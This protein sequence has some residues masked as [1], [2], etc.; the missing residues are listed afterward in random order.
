[1]SIRVFLHTSSKRAEASALLDSGATENFINEGYA[2]WL[3]IPFKRLRNPREVY[4]VDGTPNKN[5]RIEFFTDLEVRTGEQRTK[6]RFF[7]TELG[8][9]KMILGYPWFA[10]AQPRIDWAKGWIDYDQLPV[11]LKTANAG[12]F[13][14]KTV[15]K[16]RR[17][18]KE[19]LHIAYVAFPDKKQTTASKLAEQHG[20]ANHEPLPEEYRRHAKVFGEKEAQRFPGPRLWDHAIELKPNAPATIPGKI[21]ALT[22]KE[23]VALTEFIQEHLKKGYIKPSKSP[24]ASP[25]FFIKK[26]DG[27]LRPVQDYR[28]VNEWT[29]KNR[30][31]LPLIPELIAR[32]KGAKLF[33]KFDV[34][35][36]Y[37]NVRIKEGDQWKAAFITN[38]G[39]FEP[40]VM[41][42]GLT[43]SPATF[44]T[45]M[46]TIFTEEVRE[47]WLTIYMDDMLIHTPEDIKLHRRCVHRVLD[48]L[49]RHD[50]FLKPEKCHFEQ[51]TME[52]LGVVLVDG[53]IKMDPAKIKG[54]ADW[55]TPQTVR[56][57]RAFL[58]FTG[59][60]RY[61]I[62]NY[63]AIARP[64]IHLTKKATPFHWEEPQVKA[65][66]TLKTLMCRKPILR[67]PDYTQPFFVSTDASA[68][69]VGAVL[70]QEGE[71]NPRT[72][73]PSQH[74]IAYYSATFT[75][76]ERNYDIYER[77]LLAVLKALEHWRPH[78]AATDIPVTIL[79]DH[80][81][82]TFWK[83]PRKVNRRVARW[84]ATLQDYNL[85]FKHVPGKLHAAPDMLSRPPGAS[86]GEEDNQNVTLIP[87]ES[88]IRIARDDSAA[89]TQLERDITQAQEE[90]LTLMQA[91]QKTG[92]VHRV[93]S[94]L[95]HQ[96]LFTTDGAAI[97]I[98]PVDSLK[99]E[100][101]R[102]N[103]DA[104]T[105]GHP[106][107]DQTFWNLQDQ[108]WWP[109][110]R[111]WTAQYVK[112]CATCQQSKP[113]NHP[114][115]TPLYRIPVPPD[116]LPFQIVAMDLITQLPNSA[117][118][119]AILTIVDHGCSRAAIF[120]PCKTRISGE[121]IAALYLKN[122]YPWFG[123]PTKTITDR[124]PRFTS[125]FA[126]ALCAQ[127]GVRQNISTAYHPQ[128]DGLS[129][130]KNQWV[131][132]YL[133]LLTM[134]D[135]EQWAQWLPVATA[136]H[137]QVVN[138]STGA[139]PIETILGYKPPLDYRS[140]PATLNPTADLRKETAFRK[141]EQAKA[142]L[143][144]LA[145]EIPINQYGVGDQVWLEAKNL[146]LP[147][148]THKL[149]PRRHGPF[150]ITERISPVA[151]RLQLP[152]AWTIHDVFHASLLT[153][154]Q[155]TD[156][157][158]VN[159][160]KPPPDLVQ[161]EEEFEVE[162]IR[163]HRQFGRARKLQYL[164]KW[165][166]YPE[167]DNSW[168]P[169][170]QVFAPELIRRYHL[171]HPLEDK[172]ARSSRR[173]AIRL[174]SQWPPSLPN[175]SSLSPLR[176]STPPRSPSQPPQPTTSSAPSSDTDPPP[177]VQPTTSSRPMGRA[178]PPKLHS[179][180]RRNLH[181]SLSTGRTGSML[182]LTPWDDSLSRPWP[183]SA[184]P[185]PARTKS[186][187][188]SPNA[189]RSW[190]GA[191][192]RLLSPSAPR[193]SKRTRAASPTSMSK[194]TGSASKHVTFAESPALASSR[195]PSAVHKTASIC[196]SYTLNRPSS[197]TPSPIPS[198]PGLSIV[199]RP[200]PPSSPTSCKRPAPPETG[201]SKLRSSGTTS[202]TPSSITFRGSS[203]S[204]KKRR[205]TSPSAAAPAYSA[206][207][208][209]TSGTV[210][211]PSK[212]SPLCTRSASLALAAAVGGLSSSRRV[213]TPSSRPHRGIKGPR[214][215]RLLN[216]TYEASR[217]FGMTRYRDHDVG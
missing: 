152:A 179:Y 49:Q 83:I 57:V 122:V 102:Q 35:W 212:P 201:A 44:Q 164:V 12:L 33:T 160:T 172:R 202:L 24:Y 205:T 117:G 130:R 116:A 56:D 22:Q 76:T 140:S 194:K 175:P 26:K 190:R 4:N 203:V 137:N 141:Q 114:R 148:Q 18:T 68:Y 150:P 36:G 217:W 185:S 3:R 8:P 156:Q 11:V 192:L 206:S 60:Y 169:A 157:H 118:Y 85:I 43:N 207:P 138:S 213:M 23:Q 153:P 191:E 208:A 64:L 119:D 54:V 112:G 161:G 41:F 27:K 99:R 86:R 16:R 50:L 171:T 149:A 204:C 159:F 47:G 40:N 61:F 17:P 37:N 29:I 79:T 89:R 21:Y 1:M 78:V 158:G 71:L 100:I 209:P 124:D 186:S 195:A 135:Q 69:G 14:T 30:Y 52:F 193:T 182:A 139:S 84:F 184:S 216:R 95:F 19:H 136:V 174:S 51:K 145:Q 129:E 199:S 9:Q 15:K 82:L 87:P 91:W 167:A 5:G 10:A 210:S 211:L 105:A 70:S 187:A 170:E 125:H 75:P 81:N 45:M 144:R 58:G 88:F 115:K 96:P 20:K 163:S 90:H 110:M 134:N 146:A 73:K 94:P 133:R 66:E 165:K 7:L 92:R 168:E 107:R 65:F 200:I 189:S 55:P 123:I 104:P 38:Q 154:Y 101:L 67:Q 127:L 108:Y 162:S 111:K 131:E 2:R 151:Y 103:H 34:R 128:T 98:P 188:S 132:Q 142:A 72:K 48:K 214:A 147:Y 28:K 80:A 106:G 126:K 180:W 32:V 176:S 166:G 63:S 121:G 196:T 13:L 31:P 59:F 183:P 155:Q 120:L 93:H 62:P 6:M 178:F 181:A 215:E 109:G 198:Q 25:F 77:E 39:L 46:N 113:V 74:P 143:N 177:H 173:V 42:F 53:A 197:P 97:A